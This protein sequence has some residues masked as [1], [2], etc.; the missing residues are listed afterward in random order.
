MFICKGLQT[1]AFAYYRGKA[2]FKVFFKLCTYNYRYKEGKH[3]F[4][5]KL[6][7]PYIYLFVFR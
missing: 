5:R 6:W 3:F 2:A 7:V 1:K 4:L